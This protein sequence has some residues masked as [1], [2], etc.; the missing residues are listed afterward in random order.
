MGSRQYFLPP[1]NCQSDLGGCRRGHVKVVM[2][3]PTGAVHHI[4]FFIHAYMGQTGRCVNERLREYPH[5]LR[6]VP[7]GHLS[8]CTAIGVRAL[9]T[10]I[11]Q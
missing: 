5:S 8:G 11:H 6:T 4:L 2:K 9:P 10:G 1:E 3:C 7:F